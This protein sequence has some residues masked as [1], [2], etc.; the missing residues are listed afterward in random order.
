VTEYKE[1]HIL[2]TLA[3]SY[4]ES[5]DW[6]N[7]VKWSEKALELGEGEIREQ[8]AQELE[9]YKNKK[10]WREKQDVKEKP[11]AKTPIDSEFQL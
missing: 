7:A 4:A 6:E 3:S 2:S 9:S 11:E 8:L 1:S 10:P 5:G